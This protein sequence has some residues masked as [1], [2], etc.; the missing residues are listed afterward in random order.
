MGPGVTM[1]GFEQEAAF[2]SGNEVVGLGVFRLQ[3]MEVQD[4]SSS[5][6]VQ[7]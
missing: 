6:T 3:S 2:D 7:I 1:F 4:L 5:V